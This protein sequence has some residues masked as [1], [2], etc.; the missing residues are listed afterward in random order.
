M[1]GLGIQQHHAVV[2]GFNMLFLKHVETCCQ[3]ELQRKF[4]NFIEYYFLLKRSLNSKQI[5]S[6]VVSRNHPGAIYGMFELGDMG[7]ICETHENL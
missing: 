5:Y 7:I 1:V 6:T 2:L 3:K 4:D